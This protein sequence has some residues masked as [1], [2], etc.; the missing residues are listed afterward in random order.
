[1]DLNEIKRLNRIEGQVKGFQK[2][3]QDEKQCVDVLKQNISRTC[4]IT[5]VDTLLLEK[6]SKDCLLNSINSEDKEK[7]IKNLLDTVR[8][9]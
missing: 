7:T 3:I 1:M 8:N 6:Y 4:S 5:K 9:F 2:M